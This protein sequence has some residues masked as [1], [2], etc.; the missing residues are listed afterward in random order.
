MLHVSTLACRTAL[1]LLF[2]AVGLKSRK[3]GDGGEMGYSIPDEGYEDS[4]I[5][6]KKVSQ[7]QKSKDRTRKRHAA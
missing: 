2:E 6:M 4:E 7:T 1:T 3:A 5:V